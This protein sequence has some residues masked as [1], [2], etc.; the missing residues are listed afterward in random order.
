MA[1]SRREV[2]RRRWFEEK[3]PENPE[4]AGKKPSRQLGW[5][6]KSVLSK[7]L[8]ILGKHSRMQE[9]EPLAVIIIGNPLDTKPFPNILST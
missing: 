3:G 8:S 9:S 2:Y 6:R 4:N 5:S 1:G 7:P